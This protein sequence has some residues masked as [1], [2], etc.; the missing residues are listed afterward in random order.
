MAFTLA[1]RLHV[2]RQVESQA[3]EVAQ[4]EVLGL[5]ALGNRALLLLASQ[6]SFIDVGKCVR[7]AE[8]SLSPACCICGGGVS[9][10]R[11]RLAWLGSHE[12]RT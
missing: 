6:P 7:V 9:I 11:L 2:A 1:S 10:T 3:S 12:S 4:P 8:V 5:A